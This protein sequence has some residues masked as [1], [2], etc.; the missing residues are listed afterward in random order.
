MTVNI[1]G[2]AMGN[3]FTAIMAET[4]G[5]VA[6]GVTQAVVAEKTANQAGTMASILR[7]AVTAG[8]IARM[9]FVNAGLFL[10]APE[11]LV[12][13]GV[14]TIALT[15]ASK[16]LSIP[17]KSASKINNLINIVCA[18]ATLVW[19][20]PVFGYYIGNHALDL[21]SMAFLATELLYRPFAQ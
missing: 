9:V 3:A 16:Y 1:I 5:R 19:A 14:V 2:S 8:L 12:I 11:F 18:L 4:L 10:A 17:A 15:L 7:N 20:E 21:G 6:A 13:T